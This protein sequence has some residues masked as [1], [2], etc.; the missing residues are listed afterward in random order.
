MEHTVGSSGKWIL[1]ICVYLR[2]FWLSKHEMQTIL[3]SFLL[4]FFLYFWK[5]CYF[6]WSPHTKISSHHMF[7][8]SYYGNTKMFKFVIG[9]LNLG[10]HRLVKKTAWNEVLTW[11]WVL[12]YLN[13]NRSARITSFL[14]MSVNLSLF[15]SLYCTEETAKMYRLFLFL[16]Q[17]LK[18]YM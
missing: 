12:L 2:Y 8:I 4:Y 9:H 16:F 11:Y 7:I 14:I 3:S 5:S 13:K 17:I 18:M 6:F 10:W 15:L 1:R